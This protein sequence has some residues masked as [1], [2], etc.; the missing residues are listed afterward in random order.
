MMRLAI[1][2]ILGASTQS[3]IAQDIFG[4][5][6]PPLQVTPPEIRG[7]GTP[8]TADTPGIVAIAPDGVLGVVRPVD[9]PP[10]R[11]RAVGWARD[12]SR[13]LEPG[14]RGTM[15]L[16]DGQRL[17]GELLLS[18]D[19]AAWQPNW[20]EQRAIDPSSTRC[21]VLQGEDPPAAELEDVVHLRNGDR[22]SGIVQSVGGSGVMVETSAG[23]TRSTATIPWDAVRA[24]AFVAPPKP[25]SGVR[26][27]LDD[28]SVVDGTSI[29]WDGPSDAVLV[30][31][32]SQDAGKVRLEREWIVAAELVPDAIRPLSALIGEST[33]PD[34]EGT[35][36]YAVA[37]PR[38]D[39]GTWAFDAAPLVMEGPVRVA[40]ASP[41]MPARLLA[42]VRRADRAARA[43]ALTFVVRSG[44]TEVV[45]HRMATGDA[46]F[47]LRADLADA[48]FELVMLS[49]DGSIAG[50]CVELRRAVV[51]SAGRQP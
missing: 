1:I 21:I 40:C 2:A 19:R 16:H 44:G 11:D 25:R 46:S 33:I 9:V 29:V 24:V 47:E 49:D 48:P 32:R 35:M 34:G 14:K 10:G 4:R 37:A 22:A 51:V 38:S 13:R 36:R 6:P 12:D 42:T 26:V 17:V 45:R 28:G 8:R 27:W 30:G 50:D 15:V 3:V 23:G 5:T 7:R 43:G 18:D 41:G 39:R 31:Q 20:L